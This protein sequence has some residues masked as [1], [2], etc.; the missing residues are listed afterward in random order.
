LKQLRSLAPLLVL[1][2]IVS[3][4]ATLAPG[5]DPIV[6]RAEQMLAGGDAIY[7]EA[8][9]YYYKPGVAA[10]LGRDAVPIFEAFRTGYDKPYQSTQKALNTYKAAKVYVVALAAAQVTGDPAAAQI[11]LLNSQAA[12]K[13]AQTQLAIFVNQILTFLPATKSQPL[14]AGGA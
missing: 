5:A 11:T 4:C 7:S 9:A 8:M 12:L 14:N 13:D 6:V 1:L 3:S 10:T 2:L